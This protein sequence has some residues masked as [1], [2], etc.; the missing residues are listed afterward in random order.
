ML[1]LLTIE[2]KTSDHLATVQC[3]HGNTGVLAFMWIIFDH[4]I[5]YSVLN[6]KFENNYH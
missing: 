3:S 6:E 4:K 5:S 2:M 1:K